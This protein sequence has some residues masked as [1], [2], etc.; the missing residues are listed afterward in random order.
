[1]PYNPKKDI[2]LSAVLKLELYAEIPV[3]TQLY[4]KQ[5]LG[6]LKERAGFFETSERLPF[7]R[8]YGNIHPPAKCIQSWV[9]NTN[10]MRKLQPTWVNFFDILRDREV[11]LKEIAEQI[12]HYLQ[13]TA[14]RGE[15]SGESLFKITCICIMHGLCSIVGRAYQ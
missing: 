7:D 13:N 2:S 9:D 6:P 12:H 3:L 11:N 10:S 5:K 8:L 14:S 15:L 4:T 1:M